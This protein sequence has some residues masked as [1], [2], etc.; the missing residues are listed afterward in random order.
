MSAVPF[1]DKDFAFH[2][3]SKFP[4]FNFFQTNFR[5]YI[6]DECDQTYSAWFFGTTLGSITSI[7]PKLI[8]KMPWEYAK[9]K[10]SFKKEN[11]YYTEYKMEFKSKLGNGIL[12]IESTGNEV[13]LLDGFKD[14]QEQVHVLTHPIIGYHHRSNKELGTYEIRHPAIDLKEGKANSLYFEL[15]ERLGFLTKQEMNNP[16]SVLLTSKIEFDIFL[17]PKRIQ[18]SL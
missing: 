3:I 10:F 15:F 4:K 16:H 14:I 9:Y 18:N 2:R 5:A 11:K 7:I 6:I 1:K 17:P 12:D 13:K 8:W